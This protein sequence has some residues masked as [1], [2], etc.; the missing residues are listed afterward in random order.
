MRKHIYGQI[1]FLIC[2]TA[3]VFARAGAGGGSSGGGSGRASS[4]AAGWGETIIGVVLIVG[5]FIW[6]GIATWLIMKKNK[7]ATELAKKLSLLDKAWELE[8][9]YQAVKHTFLMVQHAWMEKKYYRVKYLMASELYEAHQNQIQALAEQGHKNIVDKIQIGDLQIVSIDDH[10]DDAQ[11]NFWIYIDYDL[12]DY[13]IDEKS[14]EIIS[15]S[16]T[17]IECYQELWHFIRND[18]KWIVDNIQHNLSIRSLAKM[19]ISSEA[20]TSKVS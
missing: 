11:D 19:K 10:K 6:I 3:D 16:N 9:I 15:G 4:G 14:G 2:I 12:I 20:T 5:F 17:S 1:I 8:T 7:K 13:T 18:D